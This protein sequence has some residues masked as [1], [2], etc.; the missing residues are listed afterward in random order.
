MLLDIDYRGKVRK[1]FVN[2]KELLQANYKK[3]Q[4]VATEALN[5]DWN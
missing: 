3:Q 4:I 2:D 5:T 1:L